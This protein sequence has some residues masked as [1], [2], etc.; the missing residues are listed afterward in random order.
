MRGW[1][2][3]QPLGPLWSFSLPLQAVWLC[4][5]VIQTPSSLSAVKDGV[6]KSQ[7]PWIVAGLSILAGKSILYSVFRKSYFE[8]KGELWEVINDIYNQ[9]LIK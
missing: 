3:L 1:E 9:G 4:F 8:L 6:N 7:T 5:A 2:E